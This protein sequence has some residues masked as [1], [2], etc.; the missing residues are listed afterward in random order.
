MTLSIKQKD[1]LTAKIFNILQLDSRSWS[2]SVEIV[3]MLE[4]FYDI[5]EIKE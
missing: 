3:S 1:E 2:N 5:K 4:L